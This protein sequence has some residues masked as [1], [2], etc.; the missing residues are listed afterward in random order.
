MSGV[1]EIDVETSAGVSNN[2]YY[3]YP[4][5]GDYQYWTM[6]P[7]M[8]MSGNAFVAIVDGKSNNDIISI[9]VRS[10]VAVRPVISLKS[11]AISGGTG[12][13]SDP[14]YVNEKP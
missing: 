8:F 11:D 13:S 5:N 14:F 7:Y 6:T 2:N 1:V 4:A 10:D 3:L 12:T 9:G